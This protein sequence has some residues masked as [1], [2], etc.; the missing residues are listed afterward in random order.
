MKQPDACYSNYQGHA[1]R[2]WRL[3]VVGAALLAPNATA[4]GQQDEGFPYTWTPESGLPAWQLHRVEESG[5]VGL[6]TPIRASRYFRKLFRKKF[7]APT[8]VVDWFEAQKDV[9]R[10][11]DSAEPEDLATLR[12]ALAGDIMWIRDGWSDFLEPRLLGYLNEHDLVVAD[13]ETA[14]ARSRRVPRFWTV[15]KTF[16]SPPEL[17]TSFR[18][19]DGSPTF[20]AL[21][22]AG[23]HALDF[24][25]D[26]LLETIGF[27]EEQGIPHSGA[28]SDE[29]QARWVLI[30]KDGFRVGFYAATYGINGAAERETALRFNLL[31]GVA[32][33]HG[34]GPPDLTEVRR[35]LSEM[36]ARRV[37]IKLVSLRWGYEFEYYPEPLQMQL[38]REI[39]AAGADVIMGHHSHAQQPLEVCFVDGYEE[40]LGLPKAASDKQQLCR[41]ETP[42]S[43]PRKALVIYS[44]GNFV[45]TMAGFLNKLGSVQSLTFSRS[46]TG[47]VD[48]HGARHQLVYNA[49]KD[50]RIGQ[51]RT[52]L[53]EDW[54][55]RECLRKDGCRDADLKKLGFVRGLVDY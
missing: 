49:P 46:A 37:D 16:N 1:T 2:W 18:R 41:V 47:R 33:Y 15:R 17:L 30:E 3:V 20:S 10:L 11:A 53:L 52:L 32:P 26:G 7:S 28:T 51:R 39:V 27:L 12:I 6:A 22:V 25:D 23:N 4:F 36:R 48:W 29:G 35:V 38:A 40:T 13:L 54:L 21:S 42:E 8:E 44:L 34:D 24:G 45:T 14:I 19:E 5:P 9:L 31:P 50:P 43:R 55:A